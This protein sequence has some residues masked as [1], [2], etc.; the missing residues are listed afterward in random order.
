MTEKMGANKSLML[1]GPMTTSPI[2]EKPST[3]TT[4]A[5]RKKFTLKQLATR[6]ISHI[7]PSLSGAQ[8]GVTDLRVNSKSKELM[9]LI[10]AKRNMKRIVGYSQ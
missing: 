3:T 10:D 2:Y 5:T 9:P 8:T 4:T 7:R 1:P 6:P